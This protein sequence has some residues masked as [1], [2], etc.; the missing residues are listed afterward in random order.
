MFLAGS[1]IWPASEFCQVIKLSATVITLL[2][3]SVEYAEDCSGDIKAC[4]VW[5]ATRQ[6]LDEMGARDVIGGEEVVIPMKGET[7]WEKEQESEKKEKR[8][9]ERERARERIKIAH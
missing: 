4:H 1:I 7:E 5:L 8:A 3:V 6:E 2:E 9:R